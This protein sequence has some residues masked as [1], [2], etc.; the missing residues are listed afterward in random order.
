MSYANPEFDKYYKLVTT[1]VDT[2]ERAGYI[3]KC[4]EILY[5]DCPY[6]FLCLS[7]RVQ[8]VN[9]ADWT[10]LEANSMGYF[11]NGLNDNY[12]RVEPAE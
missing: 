8:A 1:T 11:G 9:T 5:E 4:Q 3:E 6:T 2:E 12:C 10:G 7:E